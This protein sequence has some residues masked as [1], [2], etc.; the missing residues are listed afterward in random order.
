MDDHDNKIA[1]F[2]SRLQTLVEIKVRNSPEKIVTSTLPLWRQLDCIKPKITRVQESVDPAQLQPDV[3][4]CLLQQLKEQVA[5]LKHDLSNVGGGL[6]CQRK[7][8]LIYT[9]LR[10]PWIRF[11]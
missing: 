10:T 11:F 7:I 1:D 5:S 2:I 8:D 9:V 6:L 4:H 3:D